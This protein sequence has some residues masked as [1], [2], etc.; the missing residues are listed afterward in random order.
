[1]MHTQVTFYDSASGR[2]VAAFD[3]STDDAV[4]EFTSAAFSPAGDVVALGTYNRY[5][6]YA[7]N[8]ARGTWD[9]VSD[10]HA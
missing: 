4:R 1:M 6:V 5:Y 9:E 2:Q 10:E 3:Y 7:M 8:A